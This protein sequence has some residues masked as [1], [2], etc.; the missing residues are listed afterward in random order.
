MIANSR[1]TRLSGED[2][3]PPN[4]DFQFGSIAVLADDSIALA[5]DFQDW[6]DLRGSR[7]TGISG[8]DILLTV[9]E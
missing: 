4:E 9:L 6:I 8:F 7:Y 2:L 1:P 3:T 5:Q